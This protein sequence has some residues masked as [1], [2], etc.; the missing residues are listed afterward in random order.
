MPNLA[1]VNVICVKA[2]FRRLKLG[3]RLM[4]YLFE[5]FDKK[6]KDIH[7]QAVPVSMPFYHHL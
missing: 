4:N 6:R 1:I 5:H 3:T 7:L 2:T